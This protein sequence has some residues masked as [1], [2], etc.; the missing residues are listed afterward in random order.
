M[1]TKTRLTKRFFFFF[2]LKLIDLKSFSESWV[3]FLWNQILQIWHETFFCFFLNI[4]PSQN[5]HFCTAVL[6]MN[7]YMK[8]LSNK[9]RLIP[10]EYQINFSYQTAVQFESKLISIRRAKLYYIKTL[11]FTRRVFRFKS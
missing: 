10:K 6:D 9:Y 1:F 7:K 5:P 2:F 4:L 8:K 3:Y 11:P